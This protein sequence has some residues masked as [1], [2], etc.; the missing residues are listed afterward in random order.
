MTQAHLGQIGTLIRERR[1]SDGVREAAKQIGISPSTLSR[2]EN[3]K[4]PDLATFQKLCQWMGVNPSDFLS[5]QGSTSG[6]R[7]LPSSGTASAHLRARRNI[8]PELAQALGEMIGSRSA[9]GRG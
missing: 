5:V 9:H 4:Q 6:T 3:G 8:S 1:G 7:L 2:V